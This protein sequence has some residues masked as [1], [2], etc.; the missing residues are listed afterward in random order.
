MADVVAE[1][2]AYFRLALSLVPEVQQ[3]AAK[4]TMLRAKEFDVHTS[5]KYDTRVHTRVCSF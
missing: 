4:S 5:I 2:G 1:G 3:S